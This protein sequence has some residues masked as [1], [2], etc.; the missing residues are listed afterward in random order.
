MGSQNPRPVPAEKRRDK[1][2]AAARLNLRKGWA[3]PQLSLLD[4]RLRRHSCFTFRRL[5]VDLPTSWRVGQL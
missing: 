4:Y 2:G 3:S 1:D 5:I